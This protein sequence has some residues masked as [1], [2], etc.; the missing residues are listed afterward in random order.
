VQ[1]GEIGHGE[2]DWEIVPGNVGPIMR[3]VDLC[4]RSGQLPLQTP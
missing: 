3:D 4:A 2:A 1:G